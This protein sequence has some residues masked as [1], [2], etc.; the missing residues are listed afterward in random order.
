M[1]NKI[2]QTC[3]EEKLLEC[4]SFR[5]DSN[6]YRIDCKDCRANKQRKYVSENKV[7]VY[8]QRNDF[9]KKFPWMQ[10]YRAIHHRCNNPN[11]SDYKYYGGRGIKCLI[12]KDEV[13]FLWFRDKAYEMKQPTV[14]KINNDDNYYLENCRFIEQSDNSKKAHNIAILQF[15]LQN[16]FIR[17][18]E[19]IT[20][21]SEFIKRS[22][23]TLCAALKNHPSTCAGFIW[24]YKDLTTTT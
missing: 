10:S 4:F 18:W 11:A 21:A 19:S 9:Y 23:G 6:S 14:D 3:G 1:N 8:A 17:E 7:D 12:T 20:I 2:C 15:D 13:K 22:R 24:K 16:N 5:K